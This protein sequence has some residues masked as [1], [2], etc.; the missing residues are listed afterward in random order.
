ML[1]E[2]ILSDLSAM[3]NPVFTRRCS[4]VKIEENLM[5]SSVFAP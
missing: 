2:I 3:E 1:E 4:S 5:F